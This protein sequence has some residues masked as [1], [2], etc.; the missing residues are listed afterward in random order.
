MLNPYGI[1]VGRIPWPRLVVSRH[2]VVPAGYLLLAD[3]A[4]LRGVVW[5]LWRSEVSDR[6]GV[7][8]A[9]SQLHQIECSL[10]DAACRFIIEY[11]PKH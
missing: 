11:G 5:V 10:N 3:C 4:L 8:W 7:A 9:A 6:S 1:R 2:I